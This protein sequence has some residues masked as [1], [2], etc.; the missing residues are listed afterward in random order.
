MKLISKSRSSEQSLR[1]AWKRANEAIRD[2]TTQ[3]ML[4]FKPPT[5][6]YMKTMKTT[7]SE[8]QNHNNSTLNIS[9]NM[10][11]NDGI[12]D[13]KAAFDLWPS[14]MLD[15]SWELTIE[16]GYNGSREEWVK[17]SEEFTIENIIGINEVEDNDQSDLIDLS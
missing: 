13:S 9:K 8:N 2:R 3:N 17:M 11:L 15:A 5:T 6:N 14:S 1:I 12:N 4:S 16:L 10:E 7:I